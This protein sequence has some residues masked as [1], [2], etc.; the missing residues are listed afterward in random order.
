MSTAHS[1]RSSTISSAPCAPR[2]DTAEQKLDKL[3]ALMISQ[4]GR[5]RGFAV[6]RVDALD[7]VRRALRGDRDDAAGGQ[8]A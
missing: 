1:T 2:D 7:P 6:H 5:P 8:Y 3:E 4:Y